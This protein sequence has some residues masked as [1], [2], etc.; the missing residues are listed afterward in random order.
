MDRQV[1][2]DRLP[3]HTWQVP[4][5]EAIETVIS[6]CLEYQ[7]TGKVEVLYDFTVHNTYIHTFDEGEGQF[8]HILY[9]KGKT[10]YTALPL[11]HPL[12]EDLKLRLITAGF[13]QYHD[14]RPNESI[15]GWH[16]EL[17]AQGWDNLTKPA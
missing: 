15:V 6:Y 7:E 14:T 8:D 1:P 9:R 2:I 16:A 5:F 13:P 3:T 12:Y 17:K 4:S 11:H 10:D